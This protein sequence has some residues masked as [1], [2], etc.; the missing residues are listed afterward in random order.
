MSSWFPMCIYIH[1]IVSYIIYRHW[2]HYIFFEN[3]SSDPM[4]QLFCQILERTTYKGYVETFLVN[5]IWSWPLIFA[6]LCVLRTCLSVCQ[7]PWDTETCFCDNFAAIAVWLEM[8]LGCVQPSI[9]FLQSW[10]ILALSWHLAIT[11]NVC[12]E[13]NM[14]VDMYHS[15]NNTVYEALRWLDYT[16]G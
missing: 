16:S 4:Y 14:F 8:C 1:I 15:N 3:S 12:T 7:D 11:K 2:A 6:T 13:S 5:N 9:C 10:Q